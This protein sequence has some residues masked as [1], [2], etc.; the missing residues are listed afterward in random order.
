MLDSEQLSQCIDIMNACLYARREE[1]LEDIWLSMQNLCSIESLMLSVAESAPKGSKDGSGTSYTY[2]VDER[3]MASYLEKRFAKIDPVVRYCYVAQGV[4]PWSQAF[5]HFGNEVTEFVE[6][7]NHFGLVDG[8]AI[9]STSHQLTGIASVVSV[10]INQSFFGASEH[11][12]VHTL[13]PHLNAILSRPGFLSTPDFTSKQMQVL[14]WAN[15]D[16]SHWE[17]G[18][19]MGIS[20]RTVKFHFDNI[21]KKFGVRSRA[22]AV[23]KARIMGVV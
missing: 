6:L 23:R 4:F 7:A 5:E 12:M 22:E 9:G 21:F 18:S 20:E 11:I 15:L 16:K 2:G 19:I 1:D 3:W 8:F 17:T 10:S 13:L 14:H